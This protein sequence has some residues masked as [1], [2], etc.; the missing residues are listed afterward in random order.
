M[1]DDQ[2]LEMI[3]SVFDINVVDTEKRYSS[4]SR[5]LGTKKCNHTRK[6]NLKKYKDQLK[7][8]AA[9]VRSFSLSKMPLLINARTA[10]AGYG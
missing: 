10:L 7:D 2:V 8:L 5:Y 3:E 4:N 9:N 6:K 1:T